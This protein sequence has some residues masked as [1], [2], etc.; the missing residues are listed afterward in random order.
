ILEQDQHGQLGEPVSG[1]HVDVAA[2]ELLPHR[3]APVAVEAAAVGDHQG[4]RHRGSRPTPGGTA[5]AWAI[6]SHA[7]ATGR[8]ATRARSARWLRWVTRRAKSYAG[9]VTVLAA[10]S[11]PRVQV[12]P[13]GSVSRT[14]TSSV[15][16]GRP[17]EVKA[18]VRVAQ[19]RW[20][21]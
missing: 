13:D 11:G 10:S 1:D 5:K 17:W 12:A 16:A 3:G 8:V 4:Q 14:K 18:N 15:G 6:S 19:P 20:A 7:S 21:T 9:P 2:R